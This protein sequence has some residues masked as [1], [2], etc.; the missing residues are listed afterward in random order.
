MEA[1]SSYSVG[2][3]RA[4]SDDLQWTGNPFP[5]VTLGSRATV[6]AEWAALA[7]TLKMAAGSHLSITATDNWQDGLWGWQ[8]L[9]FDGNGQDGTDAWISTP[10]IVMG[11]HQE[12]GYNPL[13]AELENEPWLNIELN[14]FAE[15][16]YSLISG[17]ST[18][19]LYSTLYENGFSIEGLLGTIDWSV[20][21]MITLSGD[22][23]ANAALGFDE[24]TGTIYVTI[25]A[26]AVPEPAGYATLAGLA[27]LAWV[28]MRRSRGAHGARG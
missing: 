19:I 11:G 14:N 13:S 24:N 16:T 26:A 10:M 12:L 7:C 28:A 27:L 1:G 3:F 6:N 8:N 25:S 4:A 2:R 5:Q 17:I 15:G 20:K 22:S 23:A 18:L 21:D 9:V